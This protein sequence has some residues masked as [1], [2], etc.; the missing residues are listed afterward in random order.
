M[1]VSGMWKALSLVCSSCGFAVE[2]RSGG[3]TLTAPYNRG[4][5]V[6]I[7]V[8][9]ALLWLKLEAEVDTHIFKTIIYSV[10]L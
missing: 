1:V 4:S 6:E 9:W 2:V 7:K 5:C 3:L 10:S 8:V